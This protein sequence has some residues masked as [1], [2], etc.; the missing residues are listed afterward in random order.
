MPLAKMSL[1][2][3]RFRYMRSMHSS[4]HTPRASSPAAIPPVGVPHRPM[5]PLLMFGAVLALDVVFV[6]TTD[7]CLRASLTRIEG[8]DDADLR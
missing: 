3:Y 7:Q 8:S 1:G 6:A 4:S 5:P 2:T